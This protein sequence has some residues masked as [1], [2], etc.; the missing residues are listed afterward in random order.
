MLLELLSLFLTR[1]HG[2]S[3]E[4]WTEW[5]IVNRES[6]FAIERRCAPV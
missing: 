2:V 4:D 6:F 5:R 3:P 1:G